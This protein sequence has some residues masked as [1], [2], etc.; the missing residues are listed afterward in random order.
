MSSLLNISEDLAQSVYIALCF[1]CGLLTALMLKRQSSETWHGTLIL[2]ITATLSCLLWIVYLM[3]ILDQT[4]GSTN[5]HR[6]S[7]MIIIV[8]WSSWSLW[9]LR[10]RHRVGYGIS[11]VLFGAAAALWIALAGQQDLM[12]MTMAAAAA[13]YVIV[14]GLDNIE[15]GLK[16]EQYASLLR[17]WKAIR[18]KVSDQR[19][20]TETSPPQ[21]PT[22]H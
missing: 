1:F 11:E 17:Q 3:R 16:Q 12:T 5:T 19:S 22:N 20:E 9:Q 13:V 10:R 2:A 18:S 14:R 15:T 21:P 4:A 6:I 8:T 7:S